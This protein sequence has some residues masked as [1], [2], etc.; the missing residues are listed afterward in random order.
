[1]S[2]AIKKRGGDRKS[3]TREKLG[4]RKRLRA[5]CSKQFASA[6]D[7]PLINVNLNGILKGLKKG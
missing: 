1:M 2:G 5:R 4:E 3:G 7:F 6:S